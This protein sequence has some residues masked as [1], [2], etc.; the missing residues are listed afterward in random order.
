MNTM[1]RRKKERE[2]QGMRF[3]Q[4]L[5]TND[6]TVEVIGVSD[7]NASST[8]SGDK[9]VESKGYLFERAITKGKAPI[10]ND[11]VGVW[12]FCQSKPL[13]PDTYPY[14][15]QAEKRD[16]DGSVRTVLEFSDPT[17]IILNAFTVD[18]MRDMSV[19]AIIDK[20]V[21]GEEL[22]NEEE[23]NDINASSNF[24]VPIIYE[25]DDFLKQLVKATIIEKGININ[26]LKSKTDEKYQIPNMVAALRNSTK[27]SVMYFACWMELLGCDFTIRVN[28]DGQEHADRLKNPVIYSSDAGRLQSEVGGEVIMLDPSKYYKK[29][30]AEEE[31]S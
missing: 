17:K 9:Y 27:M 14:F 7:G 1:P 12:I 30:D 15:W 11:E 18:N 19:V 16:D 2:E 23:L 22:F 20:T 8:I 4:Y 6:R 31:E 13:H 10:E 5:N 28:D 25:R 26:K 21:P 29:E 3:P 24:Y